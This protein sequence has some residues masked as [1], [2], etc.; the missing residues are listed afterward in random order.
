MWRMPEQLA[1]AVLSACL[2]S[3]MN[4]L[5]LQSLPLLI[6]L[7]KV[8]AARSALLGRERQNPADSSTEINDLAP[9]SSIHKTMVIATYRFLQVTS[10]P[11]CLYKNLP[12]TVSN[13]F[14]REA[15]TRWAVCSFQL[16]AVNSVLPAG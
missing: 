8:A 16:F 3:C 9:L 12:A 4:H 15:M 11:M 5:A 13:G 7:Q 10:Y 6:G 1:R 14:G 2:A